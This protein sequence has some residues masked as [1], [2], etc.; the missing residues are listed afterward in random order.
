MTEMI[1][2]S[3][4]HKHQPQISHIVLVCHELTCI[5]GDICGGIPIIP[6]VTTPGCPAIY[7]PPKHISISSLA[8]S[9]IHKD[10]CIHIN[11]ITR[12]KFPC[13]L[14]QWLNG[15]QT[16]TRASYNL[17]NT[18]CRSLL[19]FAVLWHHWLDDRKGVCHNNSQSLFWPN[20]SGE[21]PDNGRVK[22]NCVC[23]CS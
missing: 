17:Q 19:K 21:T 12:L 4:C 23:V 13:L 6:F 8:Q 3:V 22:Q 10:P 15:I 5:D 7:I 16:P 20:L 18:D 2:F 11:I 14:P 1:I 9:K